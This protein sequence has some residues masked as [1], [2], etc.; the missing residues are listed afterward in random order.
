MPRAQL[1]VLA[2]LP[3]AEALCQEEFLDTAAQQQLRELFHSGVDLI[4]LEEMEV[5]GI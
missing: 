4:V 5:I 2:V 3:H 1:Q